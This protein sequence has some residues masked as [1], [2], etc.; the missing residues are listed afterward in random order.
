MSGRTAQREILD[1]VEGCV[2]LDEGECEG[3]RSTPVGIGMV[4]GVKSTV[5]FS[6]GCA[7][8]GEG[9]GIGLGAAK[10]GVAIANIVHNEAVGVLVGTKDI[11]VEAHSSV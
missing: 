3:G 9:L 4:G 8:A 10:L 11:G 1:S 5:A 6:G 2:F 7:V